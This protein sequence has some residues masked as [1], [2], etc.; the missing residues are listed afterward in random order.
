LTG[1]NEVGHND[2]MAN[3]SPPY[4]VS[5][6]LHKESRRLRPG[7][8]GCQRRHHTLTAYFLPVASGRANNLLSATGRATVLWLASPVGCDRF[9]VH[10][11][12]CAAT[13]LPWLA[14]NEQGARLIG[15]IAGAN[16]V[17]N[18]VRELLSRDEVKLCGQLSGHGLI[19]SELSEPG[20]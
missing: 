14:F 8:L 16:Q 20:L 10:A 7:D 18:F 5:G 19:G 12:H 2:D 17:G 15:R 1:A 11:K 6:R 13:N 4:L 9:P 3:L